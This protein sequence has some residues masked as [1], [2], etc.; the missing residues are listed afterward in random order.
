[1]L[2]VIS[3]SRVRACAATVAFVLL[4]SMAFARPGV[5]YFVTNTNDSG[6]D[7]L[8][9]AILDTNADSFGGTINVVFSLP[10]SG[11]W[12]INVS[13]PLPSI[14]HAMAMNGG[15]M[16]TIQGP[17]SGDGLNITTTSNV[18]GL[19]VRGFDTGVR[20]QGSYVQFSNCVV[21]G[22]STGISM[23][24]ADHANVWACKVGT[25][26]AGNAVDE[27]MLGIEI[28]GGHDNLIGST[29][30]PNLISGNRVGGVYAS[31]SDN[32]LFAGNWMGTNAAGDAPL[33]NPYNDELPG[34]SDPDINVF[35]FKA[36]GCGHLSI[37]TSTGSIFCNLITGFQRDI[38]LEGVNDAWIS[39][40]LLGLNAAGTAAIPT[41]SGS[42]ALDAHGIQMTNGSNLFMKNCSNVQVG[43]GDG[44]WPVPGYPGMYYTDQQNAFANTAGYAI[45]L[46]TCTNCS[47][48]GNL[49]GLTFDGLSLAGGR[50]PAMLY[51]HGGSNNRIGGG[52]N[53]STFANNVFDYPNRICAD[54][55]GTA[56]I[57]VSHE[58]NLNVSENLGMAASGL[59]MGHC[60]VYLNVGGSS[61]TGDQSLGIHL[62]TGGTFWN[63][64]TIY[65][66]DRPICVSNV[67]APQGLASTFNPYGSYD[68]TW[69]NERISW[70]ALDEA[71]PAGI[72]GHYQL[73]TGRSVTFHFYTSDAPGKFV[74]LGSYTP[75]VNYG[76][77]SFFAPIAV[78]PGTVLYAV[79]V[80]EFGNS[81]EFST[82]ITAA[83]VNHSPVAIV[84][85]DQ[86]VWVPH[87]G[88]PNTIVASFSLDGSA[89]FDIDPGQ[90]LTYEWRDETNTVVGNAPQIT[91]TA[92][93]GIH[94]YTLTVKDPLGAQY[95]ASTQ[96]SVHPEINYGPIV[97]G[98]A[99]TALT[100]GTAFN[101]TGIYSDGDNDSLA[102]AW[103]EGSTLL[104]ST[105]TVNTMLPVGNHVLTFIATDIYGA[106]A[107]DY[108]NVYVSAPAVN[109]GWHGFDQPINNDNSS[110]FKQGSTVPVKFS[111][112]N[113]T[114]VAHLYLAKVTNSIVGTE[115][116]AASTSAADSGNTFRLVNGGY[117]FN[118]STKGL[119]VGT[120][121]V[122]VDL[123]D[124]DTSHWVL[125]SIK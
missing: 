17:G 120:W 6:P 122:R 68:P 112:T 103:Y 19:R 111:L 86:D 78:T 59:P 20:I 75:P 62:S 30:Q 57:A 23:V 7:S 90:T 101:R 125:I 43:T 121:Q 76:S 53:A 108:V 89:S 81:S 118:L 70:P 37:G 12:T 80:D 115:M 63:S 99:D 26:T 107:L 33:M 114:P 38:Q 91:V 61:T 69:S 3:N 93:I 11:P 116:E 95:S 83:S 113:G 74:H 96:V 32:L 94:T 119:T 77:E 58:S 106:W 13:S 110:I 8:R 40:N 1:M 45:E 71:S 5:T 22:N 41:P 15:G 25:N 21:S 79:T 98:G 18:S 84:G 67:A 28:L 65:N 39:S 64:G 88:D 72:Q 46:D 117:V 48:S 10:G 16:V 51:F 27:N 102:A 124:G 123:G 104:S 82:P 49:V 4:S 56:M 66:C 34:L 29:S 54:G 87:D 24:N 60:H 31:A 55:A 97:D 100:Y 50:G 42:D 2:K 105:A 9:Q 73:P 109:Y 44:W 36:V 14:T 35:G 47:F 52:V 85:A 92:P